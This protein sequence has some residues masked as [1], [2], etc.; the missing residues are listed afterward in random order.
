MFLTSDWMAGLLCCYTFLGEEDIGQRLMV[1]LAKEKRLLREYVYFPA[2]C[3]KWQVRRPF[4]HR[5]GKPK[6]W[7]RCN[8]WE[9]LKCIILC[10]G[11]ITL[12]R[13]F[14]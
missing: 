14:S 8:M 7:L 13:S 6:W 2:H 1:T 9:T 3:S 5:E 12:L 10:Y 11:F 4:D